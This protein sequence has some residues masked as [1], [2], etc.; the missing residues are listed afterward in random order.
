MQDR[1]WPTYALRNVT[2]EAFVPDASGRGSMRVRDTE[3]NEYLDAIGGIGCLPLGHGHPRWI[4]ALHA[5]MQ[6]LVAAAGPFWTEPQQRLAAELVARSPVRDARVFFGNT[7]TEVT[8][9]AIKLATRATGRDVIIAFYNAF[10]GRTLGSIALT[11]TKAYRDPYVSTLDE[12]DDRFAR[13]NVARAPFGDL[14]AVA[15][16]FDRHRD[17]VAMVCVEPVQGEGGIRPA[18]REFLLGV[19]ELCRRHGALLGLDEIQSGVGRTG[20]FAAFTTLAGDDVDADVVWYAK[21]LGGGYPIAACVTRAELAE[22]MVKGSHGSTFGGNPLACAAGVATLAIMDEEN[23]FAAAARQLPTLQRIAAADPIDGVH[24]VRGCGAMIGIDFGDADR[25]GRAAMQCQA[26]GLLATVSG[27]TA[28]R[29]L[30]PYRAG[31]DELTQ[32]W[33]TL[34]AAVANASAPA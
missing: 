16:L 11:G 19:R 18:T 17:R 21:A 8:E 12:P 27:G 22:H 10:H 28:I 1:R 7:G 4:E 9:G 32:A 2:L 34:R 5:Q 3:G 25:A 31:E 30:F 6:R 29:W 13:M 33:A 20:S 24:E 23:L 14:E 15:A 26:H